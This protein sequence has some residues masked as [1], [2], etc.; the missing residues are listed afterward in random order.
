MST[1]HSTT[2][3]LIE[4]WRSRAGDAPLPARTAIDPTDFAELLPRVFMLGRTQSGVYPLRLVGGFVGDLHGLDLRRRNALSLWA[5][6][7]RSGLQ[8]AL[9]ESRR[10]PEPLV[11]L[12]DLQSDAGAMAMEVLYAPLAGPDGAADR[13]LGLY[14]PLGLTARL[15]GG[16][17]TAMSLRTLRRADGADEAAP[18]LRLA[19]LHGRRIA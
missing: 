14:Q 3:R 15:R 7:D 4:Y 1:F 16:P 10:R 5:E 13:F 17:I 2:E 11:A 8:T 19:T 6:R 12:A 9:E 18:R